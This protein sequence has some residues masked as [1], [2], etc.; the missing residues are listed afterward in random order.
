MG[1]LKNS[2]G[3]GG[4][5]MEV[6]GVDSSGPSDGFPGFEVQVHSEVGTSLW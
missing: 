5:T 2:Q 6:C 4:V 1:L 3:S